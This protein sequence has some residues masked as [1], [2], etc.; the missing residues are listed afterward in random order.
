MQEAALGGDLRSVTP[1]A[2]LRLLRRATGLEVL[3]ALGRQLGRV[4]LRWERRGEIRFEGEALHVLETRSLLGK[5]LFERTT[6]FPVEKLVSISVFDRRAELAQSAGLGALSAGTLLGT[7]LV[8]QGLRTPGFAPSVVFVGLALASVGGVI[9]FVCE[10]SVARAPERARASL[11]IV[12]ARGPALLLSG[13]P[14]AS[15]QRWLEQARAVL[16]RAE[17]PA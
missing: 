6:L 17:G 16:A 12:P 14:P 13:L 8:V 11:R 4:L 2:A 1:S 7:G 3:L 9:D 5:A 10:R 15:A